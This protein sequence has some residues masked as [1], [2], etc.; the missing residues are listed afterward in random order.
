ELRR[1]GVPRYY[2]SIPPEHLR[3]VLIETREAVLGSF[4][5]SSQKRARR[6]L[7]AFGV[8]LRFGTSVER[9]TPEGV[10]LVGGER[11][12][13]GTV[14]WAAGIRA[15]DVATRLGLPTGPG[16]RIRVTPNLE[17]VGDPGIFAAGG[18]GLVEGAERLPPVAQVAMQG[19]ARAARNILPAVAGWPLAAVPY[20]A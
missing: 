12:A 3:I 16:G 10:D 5:V 19:G 1:Q 2:P 6:D 11:L 9:V 14:V 17:A 13:A 4:A 20:R 15:A 7:E 18:V 8:E